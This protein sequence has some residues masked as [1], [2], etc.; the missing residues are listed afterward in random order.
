MI[1][2][3]T[4]RDMTIANIMPAMSEVLSGAL[5]DFAGGGVMVEVELADNSDGGNIDDDGDDEDD[6][7][8]LSGVVYFIINITLN[9]CEV[10]KYVS[11]AAHNKSVKL[12]V[13]GR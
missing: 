13:Y 3:M 6:D 8:E 10:H 2:A 4:T 11:R 1:P 9:H 7:V 5:V 12:Q